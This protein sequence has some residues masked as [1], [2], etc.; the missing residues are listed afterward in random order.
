MR[1][2]KSF[3]IRGKIYAM[4]AVSIIAVCS[5]LVIS[6]IQDRNI[7][8]RDRQAEL[9]DIVSAAV[10]AVEG[11]DKEVGAGKMSLANAQEQAALILWG[12]QWPGGGYL[13]VY[14]YDGTTISFIDRSVIGQ[15]R[16]DVTDSAGVRIVSEMIDLAK[17]GGGDLSYVYPHASG[18]KPATKIAY[19]AGYQ[20]W[21][22]SISAGVYVDDVNGEAIAQA[23]RTIGIGLFFLLA[24]SAVALAIGRDL[25]RPLIGM[26]LA[27][28]NLTGGD[29]GVAIPAVERRDE[30]G[31]MAKSVAIFKDSMV[32]VRQ[33][34][35][36]QQEQKQ[37]AA[38][39]RRTALHG[40]ADAFESHVGTVIESVSAAAAQLQGSS[41]RM[42]EVATDTSTRATSV[43]TASEQASANVQTVATATEE[44]SSSIREISS[45]VDRSLSVARQA[46]EK[47]KIASR[48]VETLAEA[49][50][51]IGEIIAL[52]DDV[53]SQTNL[54]ALNATIEAARAGDAG[55]G[56]AVVAGEVKGLASQTGKATEQITGKIAAVQSGTMDAVAAIGAVAAV[57][58]DMR[59]ISASVAA[60]VEQQSAATAEIAR[61]VDQAALG[62]HEVSKNIVVVESE[63]RNTG[64][65]ATH[66]SS[67]SSELNDNADRLSQE[68]TRF[69]RQVRS[70]G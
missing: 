34:E 53:A 67:A 19:S 45:Q 28:K 47:A 65:I 30:I 20:P 31:D 22:W 36:E 70:E 69:L 61:N 48:L 17:R 12:M 55:K 15:N 56:F 3:G 39:E 10:N 64:A 8:I 7:I 21:K 54:L 4:T 37:R 23:T 26:T 13:S 49:V 24:A 52:I 35:V 66:I 58:D 62:T 32:R 6:V 46:D 43:A 14:D 41:A 63:A 68:V 2:F 60:A 57:I 25:S 11:L 42:A 44:L 38:E 50:S 51:S 16:Q 40:M 29:L 1:I 33:M 18:G 59:Q 5:V 9:V 27:M